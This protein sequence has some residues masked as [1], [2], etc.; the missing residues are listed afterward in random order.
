MIFPLPRYIRIM[1]E[2]PDKERAKDRFFL[3]LACIYASRSGRIRVL[4]G[5]IGVNYETLK[6]Q[7]RGVQHH[8]VSQTTYA[9][10]RRL[11]G[12]DFMP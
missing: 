12:R 4:A 9:G 10:V 8:P 3:Q 7:M 5:L 1:S 6:S 2:G 11:L